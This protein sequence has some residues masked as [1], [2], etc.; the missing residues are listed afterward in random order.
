MLNHNTLQSTLQGNLIIK[1]FS[2][3]ATNTKLFNDLNHSLI[4]LGQ[5]CDD[6]CTVIMTK[7]NLKV[8]KNN[9]LILMDTRST[10]DDGLWDIP[11]PQNEA[12]EK[13]DGP[14]AKNQITYPT[15]TPNSLDIILRTDKRA[16][17]LAAYLH[18]ACFLPVTHTFLNA[19]NFFSPMPCLNAFFYSKASCSPTTNLTRTYQT[20][21]T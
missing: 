15:P 12:S 16:S 13:N 4:S 9:S 14:K 11:I 2:E 19:I 10:T 6:N 8:I 3:R 1:Y 7:K 5:L 17:D 20:R 21:K 18:A